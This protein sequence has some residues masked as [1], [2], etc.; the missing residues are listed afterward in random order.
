MS[1]ELHERSGAEKISSRLRELANRFLQSVLRHKNLI[2]QEC[3]DELI[4]QPYL[5][6]PLKT[7]LCNWMQGIR[8]S[9]GVVIDCT[10]SAT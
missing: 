7:L 9:A 5:L 3:I 2:V 1:D 6:N 10:S 4:S 8:E